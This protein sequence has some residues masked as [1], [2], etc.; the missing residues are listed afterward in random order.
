MT[1]RA[2]CTSMSLH[3]SLTCTIA[4]RSFV[5]QRRVAS[6]LR[7]VPWK[8]NSISMILKCTSSEGVQKARPGHI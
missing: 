5:R 7:S 8:P 6:T 1:T 2:L 4:M 3:A